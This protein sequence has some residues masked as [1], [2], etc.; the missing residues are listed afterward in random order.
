MEA[1][2]TGATALSACNKV[3][4]G[5][6]PQPPSFPVAAATPPQTTW[7]GPVHAV[8]R[9]HDDTPPPAAASRLLHAAHHPPPSWLQ[10]GGG[11]L[12]HCLVTPHAL[13]ARPPLSGPPW[14]TR[15]TPVWSLGHAHT[16]RSPSGRAGASGRATPL[17]TRFGLAVTG[18][19]PDAPGAA[20]GRCKSAPRVSPPCGSTRPRASTAAR[21][22]PTQPGARSSSRRYVSVPR[23]RPRARLWHGSPHL[24]LTAGVP[25]LAAC[26][27]GLQHGRHRQRKCCMP[28]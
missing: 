2:F 10:P 13:A 5:V 26:G 7:L 22:R 24:V 14:L 23:S 11:Q 16:H 9:P 19:M 3:G 4:P 8:G 17:S 12:A 1:T 21:R 18:P 28:C 25:F 15:P 27:C 6:K 20:R